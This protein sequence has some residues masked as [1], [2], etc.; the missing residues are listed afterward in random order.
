LS[1][2]QNKGE[3]DAHKEHNVRIPSLEIAVYGE[4]EL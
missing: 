2:K 4:K 1:E 3:Y